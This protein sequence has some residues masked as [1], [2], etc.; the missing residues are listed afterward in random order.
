[1]RLKSK[2]RP[3]QLMSYRVVTEVT[4]KIKAIIVYKSL[5]KQSEARKKDQIA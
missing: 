4:P 1:M 3:T 2:M 5:H